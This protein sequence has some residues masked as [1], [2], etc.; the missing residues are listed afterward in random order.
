MKLN[1]II[2]NLG[3]LAAVSLVSSCDDFLDE[4]PSRGDNEVLNRGE[5]IKNLFA[6]SNNY[7]T[8]VDFLVAST[9]DYGVTFDVFDA[10][11][12]LDVPSLS[13]MSWA[14]E[15][16][17][18]F[19]SDELWTKQYNKIFT[20]N[21]VLSEIEN[22]TDITE[23]ER[24]EYLAHAHFVRALAYW[25]LAN[26]YCLPYA[27]ENL[28]ALGLPLKVTTHTDEDL[29]RASLADTYAFIEADLKE[30]LKSP[31]A[32]IVEG[33]RW[34]V[35]QPAAKAL[36]ARFYLFTGNYAEAAKYADE[37]LSSRKATL[38]DYNQLTTY[39]MDKGG[40]GF[41]GD[42]EFTGEEGEDGE[43]G[44]GNEEYGDG[45]EGQGEE[46]WGDE[47]NSNILTFCET[48]NYG[49]Y[50]FVDYQEVFY[51]Q[52]YTV[53]ATVNLLAS[54][55]LTDLYDKTNDLRYINLFVENGLVDYWVYGFNDICNYH[56]FSSRNQWGQQMDVFLGASPTVAEMYLTKAEAMARQGAWSEALNVLMQLRATRFVAGSDYSISANNQ[57]EALAEILKERRRELP[58]VM[59]W[60]DIRR[61][62]Y[63]ET[64]ED[65]VELHRTFYTIENG[66]VD[67]NT[68]KEYVLPVK[69][70]RY[71]QPILTTEIQRSRGQI[72]QNQY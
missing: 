28:Q 59:R 17:D 29:T 35:S 10:L 68:T 27:Q 42:E 34:L 47:G 24:A 25:E 37:A 15:G 51:P 57:N 43:Y 12:Y 64:P 31:R 53:T 71:A 9:D 72:Q 45:E 41:W 11:G 67:F 60:Y 26:V 58:F 50:Q 1:H 19:M 30:A 70:K 49:A 18:V 65:D 48:Y 33:E 55:E 8:P 44:D 21:A 22:V 20:A 6:N 63:N 4:V 69:S 40:G 38:I 16:L 14:P 52:F 7:Y 46:E 23:E 36:M 5:Q 54:Q 39:D 13:G 66:E 3:L 56:L 32:D 61:F 2:I 62:A